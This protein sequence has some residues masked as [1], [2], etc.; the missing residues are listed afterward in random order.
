MIKSM[1]DTLRLHSWLYMALASVLKP[2]E[3]MTRLSH[4]CH[5]AHFAGCRVPD[6]NDDFHKAKMGKF[7]GFQATPRVSRGFTI[8]LIF[9]RLL[10]LLFVVSQACT[11]EGEWVNTA[12]TCLH[13]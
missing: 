3:H 12:R 10:Y 6:K 13:K 4:Y 8:L 2:Q 1:L 5:L 7:L 11:L 9:T